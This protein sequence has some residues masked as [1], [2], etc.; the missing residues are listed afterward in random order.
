MHSLS[1]WFRSTGVMPH[2]FC[3]QWRP[4]LLWL[5]AVSD[6]LIALAYFSI[7]IVLIYFVRR[8]RDLPFGWMWMVPKAC[9]GRTLPGSAKV[10]LA[11]K[12]FLL[13][14]PSFSFWKTS[15]LFCRSSETNTH[16][17]EG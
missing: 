2:G 9:P 7:P 6:A 4:G 5:H 13:N 11:N 12:G 15:S 14:V 1:E 17:R 16:G 3:Y 8:R 10:S